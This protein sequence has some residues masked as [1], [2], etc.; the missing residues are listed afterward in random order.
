MINNSKP[1]KYNRK[2]PEI[3]YYAWA[4]FVGIVMVTIMIFLITNPDV[5]TMTFTNIG[6]AAFATLANT[7]FA[8]A[9]TF[10]R[11]DQFNTA[12]KINRISYFCIFCAVL[13]LVSSLLHFICSQLTI[14]SQGNYFG[15]MIVNILFYIRA[16]LIFSFTGI[17]LGILYEILSVIFNLL[18][19]EYFKLNFIKQP[20]DI[21]D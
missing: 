12:Y 4:C 13:F 6:F 7:C 20:R 14:Y 16:M 3:F 17:S 9:R 5:I 10:I 21:S 15:V 11:E 8:W 18:F 2:L 19:K 1:E